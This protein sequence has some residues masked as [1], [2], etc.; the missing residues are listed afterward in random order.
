MRW[1]KSKDFVG[2]D[3]RKRRAALRPRERRLEY[4]V[5]DAPSLASGLLSLRVSAH[6]AN[7]PGGVAAFLRRA[8]AVGELAILHGRP[9][10]CAAL[11]ALAE[12]VKL[13]PDRDWQALLG[14]QLALMTAGL[15][16]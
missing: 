16:E 13:E 15:D 8:I 1:V 9:E 2:L 14:D 11:T 6:E 12:R 4:S 5:V 3:R 10:I 7:T